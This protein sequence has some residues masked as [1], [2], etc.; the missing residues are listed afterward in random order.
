M[1]KLTKLFFFLGAFTIGIF[2]LSA[3]SQTVLDRIAAIVDDDIILE[4]EV[5]QGAYQ[6]AMQLGIDVTKNPKELQ[7]LAAMT[8]ENLITVKVLLIQAEKDTIE[9]NE[10]QVD[11]S[12][13]QQMQYIAQQLGGEDKAEAYFGMPLSKIRRSFRSQ[14]EENLRVSAVQGQKLADVSVTRRE[15]SQFFATMKDSIGSVKEGVDISHILIR[16]KPGEEAKRATFEKIKNI[17]DRIVAGED[18]AALAKEVSEDPGSAARGGELGFMARGDFVR[19]FEEAA[20]NLKP[21][22]MSD[23]VQSEFGYHIIQLLE[24]RGEKINARH[25]LIS[26]KPTRED[27]LAAAEKIKQIHTELLG[28]KSF[29]EMVKQYSDDESTKDADGRL[30]YFEINQLRETAKE[31]VFA[32]EGIEAGQISEPVKTQYG[33]HILKV[34]SREKAREYSLDRDWDRIES[35]AVEYKKQKEFKKWLSE[36]KKNIYIEIKQ[37]PS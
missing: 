27:E 15:V 35:M 17:R 20:F 1:S 28:G 14:I 10:K 9:A 8:L 33:F 26:I 13:E 36:L 4:S 29:A 25:I 19:E 12:L 7:R 24:R 18:F 37:R 31:F 11:A 2:H 5:S 21:E 3:Q 23:I 6:L 16:T 34:N 30:G 22:E 32:L